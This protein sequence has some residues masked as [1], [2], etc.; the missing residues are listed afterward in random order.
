MRYRAP[1]S[2]LLGFVIAVLTLSAQAPDGAG[3]LEFAGSSAW[4]EALTYSAALATAGLLCALAPRLAHRDKPGGPL[5]LGLAAGSLLQALLLGVRL[6]LPGG[7]T[8][9]GLWIAMACAGSIFLLIRKRAE[10]PEDAPREFGLLALFIGAGGATL[11]LQ[12]LLRLVLR[13]GLGTPLERDWAV[14]VGLLG[15]LAGGLAFGRFLG[16]F[17]RDRA[18]GLTAGMALAGAGLGAWLGGRAA[19]LLVTPRGIRTFIRRFG[20]DLSESGT[21]SFGGIT[22]LAFLLVPVF[23]VGTA[24]YAARGRRAR[25][26]IALGAALAPLAGYWLLQRQG[27]IDLMQGGQGS[28]SLIHAGAWACVL[29]GAL[30]L[31]PGSGAHLGGRVWAAATGLITC[32]ALLLAGLPSIPVMQ[33]WKRFPIDPISMLELPEGQLIV[34]PDGS[35]A[36]KATLDQREITTG[37][38]G[39]ASERV[40][41]EK[42]MQLLDAEVRERGVRVLL[43]GQLDPQRAELLRAAGAVL[44]DRSAAWWR[45]MPTME[46]ELNGGPINLVPGEIRSLEDARERWLS[47]E[48]DLILALARPGMAPAIETPER[49]A[50]TTVVLWLDSAAPLVDRHLGEQLL[51]AASGLRQ[52]VLAVTDP[53][54]AERAQSFASGYAR[55]CVLPIDRLLRREWER[56]DPERTLLLD[57]LAIWNPHYGRFL[58]TLARLCALQSHSSPFATLSQAIELNPGLVAE[59]CA[60][61]TE[62]GGD[63]LVYNVLVGLARVLMERRDIA[64]LLECIEPLSAA[65]GQPLDL[66]VTL[67]QADLESLDPA[68]SEARLEPFMRRSQVHPDVWR[69]RGDALYQLGRYA[70]AAELWRDLE[71]T[72]GLSETYRRR[73]ALALLRSGAPQGVV[74]ARAILLEHPEDG[75]LSAALEAGPGPPPEPEFTPPGNHKDH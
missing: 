18:R 19:I 52:L 9:L 68:S 16:G 48:Y 75:E 6:S 73:Y 58:E 29:A 21:L 4:R 13:L 71:A 61:A 8:G 65:W 53:V 43:V 40:Q 32:A 42:S 36:L 66:V 70:E 37:R 11:A 12:G 5:L 22:T 69:L 20:G 14:C 39:L 23:F 2:F 26:C 56:P 41:V 57:R 59:L 45:A 44:L 27:V 25:T 64:L 3:V 24:L 34:V 7:L 17:E 15:A 10:E 54:T 47:G 1:V 30:L 51:L 74:L 33:A 67:A 28:T 49:I 60:S 31:V 62:H 63:P 38:A 46:R 55:G 50:D 72:A 35:G